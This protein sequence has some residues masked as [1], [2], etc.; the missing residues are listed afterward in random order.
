MQTEK[1]LCTQDFIDLGIEHC[2]KCDREETEKT[3]RKVVTDKIIY[4]FVHHNDIDELFICVHDND[5][6]TTGNIKQIFVGFIKSK[7]E[8]KTLLKFLNI[9]I[10][11]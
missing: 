11:N 8:L 7:S 9:Q 3:Y 10:N 6:F 2:I 5:V 1:Q 4:T